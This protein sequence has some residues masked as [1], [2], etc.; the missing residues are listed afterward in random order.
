MDFSEARDD[1][2]TVASAGLYANHLHFAPD[3]YHANTT[4]LSW[5]AVRMPFLLPN[6][7]H[8]STDGSIAILILASEYLVIIEISTKYFCG[9]FY[10]DILYIDH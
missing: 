1:G 8:Q 10:W 4:P 6:Q 9:S 2:V 3:R 7:Q 5:F